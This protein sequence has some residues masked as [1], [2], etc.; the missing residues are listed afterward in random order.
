MPLTF[1]LHNSLFLFKW[2][3]TKPKSQTVLV[4]ALPLERRS[5]WFCWCSSDWWCCTRISHGPSRTLR[6]S[7]EQNGRKIK[8]PQLCPTRVW[9]VQHR[10]MA[11]AEVHTTWPTEPH[12]TPS[13]RIGTVTEAPPTEVQ[14]RMEMELWIET[15]LQQVRY[16]NLYLCHWPVR[17]A[18]GITET[19]S[20]SS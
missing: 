8:M 6:M 14:R 19:N 2:S 10:S 12:S 4:Q 11:M 9:R 13:N 5:L 1:H 17:Q 20:S 3:P 15:D 16:P 7:R 18:F